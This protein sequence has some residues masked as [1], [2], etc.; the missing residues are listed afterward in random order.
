MFLKMYRSVGKRIFDIASSSAVVLV[1]SPFLGITALSI[2][3]EDGGPA[4]FRQRRIGRGGRNFTLLKFRSMP[5]QTQDVPSGQAQLV[6]ITR[7][8]RIIRRTNLDEIPQLLNILKGD[9]SVVGPRPALSSQD[10]LLK[11]RRENGAMDCKPGL[12]GLAQINSYDG[13]SETQKA[14]WDGKYARSVSFLQDMKIILGT[15]RYLMKSPPV[16]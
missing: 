14:Q 13:M 5:V 10:E 6:T 3:L 2:R 4:L 11:I 12:T 15:L 7:V 9:M 8:G 16:Y 1:L